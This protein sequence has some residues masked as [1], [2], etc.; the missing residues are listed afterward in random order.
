MTAALDMYTTFLA[1]CKQYGLLGDLATS[2]IRRSD[3]D[4]D[5]EDVGDMRATSSSGSVSAGAANAK[6]EQKIAVFKRNKA[7]SALLDEFAAKQRLVRA[8]R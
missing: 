2:I 4:D 6:R 8:R 7:I 1:L 5:E 3:D